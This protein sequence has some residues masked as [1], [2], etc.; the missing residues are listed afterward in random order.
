MNRRK[1]TS[2]FSH[3]FFFFSVCIL[4]SLYTMFMKKRTENTFFYI[5]SFFFRF[6]VERAVNLNFCENIFMLWLVRGK[7]K[8]GFYLSLENVNAF[9]NRCEFS[10][11]NFFFYLLHVIFV[12][13]VWGGRKSVF[14]RFYRIGEAWNWL[15]L[16]KTFK[17]AIEAHNFAS[18]S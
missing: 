17:L 9:S 8:N 4:L 7:R 18:P 15:M 2:H 14:G 3:L 16:L 6:A 11:W 1:K 13:I 12:F 5:S 10:I